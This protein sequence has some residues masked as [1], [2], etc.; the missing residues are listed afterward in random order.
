M[1]YRKK[2]INQ[3]FCDNSAKYISGLDYC[4]AMKKIHAFETLWEHIPNIIDSFMIVGY[5]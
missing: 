1:S 3:K 4:F 2:K 5:F